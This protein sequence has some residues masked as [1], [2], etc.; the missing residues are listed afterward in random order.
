MNFLGLPIIREMEEF[1]G[2]ALCALRIGRSCAFLA[3]RVAGLAEIELVVRGVSRGAGAPATGVWVEEGP[4]RA[5]EAACLGVR[6][7]AGETGRVAELAGQI[8]VLLEVPLGAAHQALRIQKISRG[9][10]VF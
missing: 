7:R 4:L 6:S 2:V 8:R 1:S 5:G 3:A 10:G 9:G